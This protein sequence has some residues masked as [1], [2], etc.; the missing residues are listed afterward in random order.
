M[1]IIILSHGEFNCNAK[2]YDEFSIDLS[3]FG[4]G[5]H[6]AG[7]LQQ[8][9][10]EYTCC[11]SIFNTHAPVNIDAHGNFSTCQRH[12]QVVAHVYANTGSHPNCTG[13]QHTTARPA[14]A[15]YADAA[16]QEYNVRFRPVFEGFYRYSQEEQYARRHI[17]GYSKKP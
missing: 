2:V 6:V 3:H 13:N 7:R 4:S 10:T 12:A 9:F 15:G 8:G 14:H 11:S 16:P 5:Q 17:R 1:D